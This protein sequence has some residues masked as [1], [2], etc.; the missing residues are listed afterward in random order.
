MDGDAGAKLLHTYLEAGAVERSWVGALV[1]PGEAVG[2]QLRMSMSGEN[3]V[4]GRV[5]A[6]QRV[7]A[8]DVSER[9]FCMSLKYSLPSL[10]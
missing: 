1:D 6:C 3:E 5:S 7:E 10:G 9:Q 2:V 4:G 8:T